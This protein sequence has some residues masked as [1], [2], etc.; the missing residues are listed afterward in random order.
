MKVWPKD[1]EELPSLSTS[2]SKAIDMAEMWLNDGLPEFRAVMLEMIVR[3][4]LE[5]DGVWG[6]YFHGCRLVEEE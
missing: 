2:T 4:P 1:A 5:E 6:G 3:S